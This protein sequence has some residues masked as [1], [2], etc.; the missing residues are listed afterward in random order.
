M[1]LWDSLWIDEDDDGDV[2]SW[3]EH[4][5]WDTSGGCIRGGGSGD[6]LRIDDGETLR[7]ISLR[8]EDGGDDVVQI[9]V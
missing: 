3:L 2:A 5:W 8:G 9:V 6:T 1:Y 4:F 7:L